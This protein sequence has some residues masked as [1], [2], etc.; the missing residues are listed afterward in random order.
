VPLETRPSFFCAAAQSRGVTIAT[1]ADRTSTLCYPLRRD[2]IAPS[3][4]TVHS[5]ALSL[6]R[7]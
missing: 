2:V 7:P 4:V 6:I 1:L 5:A 3:L